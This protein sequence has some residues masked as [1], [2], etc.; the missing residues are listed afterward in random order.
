MTG[1]EWH[2]D[3]N[4]VLNGLMVL[5]MGLVAYVF[6]SAMAELTKNIDRMRGDIQ[7]LYD[8]AAK[9]LDGIGCNARKIAELRGEHEAEMRRDGH[10]PR[11]TPI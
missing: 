11:K 7:R 1:M 4:L 3:V 6:K 10:R 2:L 8:T 9:N 5:I